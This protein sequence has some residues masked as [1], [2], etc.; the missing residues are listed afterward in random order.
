MKRSASDRFL[1]YG[2]LAALLLTG[3]QPARPLST[4]QS[5]ATQVASP[6]APVSLRA[7]P[8]GKVLVAAHRGDWRHAHE[9]SL[10]AIQGCIDK[11]VDM[12]EI[13]VARTRDGH[14]V[15]MHDKTVDRT[16]TGTGD[17]ANFTLDSL[18]KLRVRNNLGHPTDYRVP[19]LEEA[20]WLAKGRILVNLDKCYDYLP[21][22]YGVLK[23]T[24]TVEQALFK[25]EKPLAAVRADYGALLDSIHYMPILT[26]RTPDPAGF[27][28]AFLEG[29]RPFAFELIFARDADPLLNVVPLITQAGEHVWINTLWPELCGGHDDERA[30]ADPDGSWGW[31]LYKGAT[32]LQ[33]DRPELLLSYLRK[34]GL[35]P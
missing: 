30:L 1:L 25:G 24:G 16:T 28:R 4:A 13:D 14:L 12:V 2:W 17:V 11:G 7:I 27:V 23:A 29:A 8:A 5:N 10:L 21:Q 32:L 6:S 34:R 35:H 9:N 22:A 26:P 18:R 33:T 19:T 3:C 20:M 31:A 15:L